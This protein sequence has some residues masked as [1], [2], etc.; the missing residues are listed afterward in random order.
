MFFYKKGLSFLALLF[1]ASTVFSLDKPLMAPSGQVFDL[2]EVNL[3]D[4]LQILAKWTKRNLVLSPA[5]EGSVSLHVQNVPLDEVFSFLLQT[6]GLALTQVGELWYVSPR[7]ALMKDKQDEVK[8]H[9]LL[10]DSAPVVTTFWELQYARAE[11]LAQWLQKGPH[12][13]LS[14]RGQVRS[15]AGSNILILQDTAERMTTLTG[16]IKRLDVPVKQVLIEARLASIDSDYKEELGL[17]FSVMKPAEPTKLDA[18][19]RFGLVLAQ[20]TDN[21]LLDVKLSAMENAGHGELISSP[22][23]LTASQQTASIEAGEEIPYQESTS[24]GA[25]TVVF[26]KAVLSLQVRPQILPG[27]KVLLALQVNQDR[28]NTRLVL[29]VPTIS[30]RQ[31]KTVVLVA[32]GHTVVLGGI[33]ELNKEKNEES[34]PFLGKLPLVGWLFQEKDHRHSK[35]ELLV[36]VTPRIV[37]Y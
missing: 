32:S 30:T 35:R 29:G 16:L 4:A 25:T 6:H 34:L 12:S 18:Y 36:F 19:G 10:E 11:E 3:R 15:E 2:K 26:K 20:L 31:M 9:A 1:F 33:Y 37:E 7:A 22:S 17:R 23:L 5:I 27:K 13:L 28:P 24:S 21:H 14:K 8:W